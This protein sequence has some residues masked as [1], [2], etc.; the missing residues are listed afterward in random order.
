MKKQSRIRHYH[1]HPG[2][3]KPGIRNAISDVP[4]VKVGHVTLSHK[5][6]QTG[7]TA[8]IPHEGNL[9]HEKV[10]AASHVINGFG[11][12][13]G[14]IQINELGTIETPIV[15]TNTLSAGTAADGLTDYMLDTY[16]DIGS[17]TGTVN[18]VVGEC[19]DMLLNDI[20]AKAVTKADVT[21]AIHHA[22]ADFAEGTAGAGTGM[23]CYSLKGG[24]GSASRLISL[25][26][27]I[28]TLGV[29]VLTN[30]G[31]LPDLTIDGRYT[32]KQ[33]S[34]LSEKMNEAPDKGSV[35]IIVATDLPV[36]QNQLQRIIKRSVTGLS[37]TGA[38]IA[39]GS[40]DIVIGFSTANKIPHYR[41]D[42]LTAVFNIHDS[43]LDEP[44][45]AA[46]EATEE[47]VLNSLTAATS[48]TGH[49]KKS[50]PS[51]TEMLRKHNIQL[52]VSCK[53]Q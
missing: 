44:F 29:L 22:S 32:G 35:M 13:I 11:K 47:A 27:G 26:Y 53:G 4:G 3:L 31:S 51:L 2:R 50:I 28:Y 23:V 37:R 45:R 42:S 46:G 14:T 33:L 9:F 38:M 24:I 39:H 49:N 15:L 36:T 21:K 20:R 18:P 16:S 12:S 10:M 25:S 41:P 43:D 5:S 6:I 48:V 1:I 40:G 7:V 19:N 52:G 30:F 17:T 8:I 34:S